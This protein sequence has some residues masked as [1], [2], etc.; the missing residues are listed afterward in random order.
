M[1]QQLLECLMYRREHR[2]IEL[3]G[4][5]LISS[6][7]SNL[8]VFIASLRERRHRLYVIKLGAFNVVQL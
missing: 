6:R 1:T 2:D 5:L 4:N 3:F 7:Q 8:I